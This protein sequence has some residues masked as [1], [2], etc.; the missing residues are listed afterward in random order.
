[1]TAAAVET[2]GLSKR[3]PKVE[4]LKE[5]SLRI[6][7]GEIVALLGPNGAGKTTW[8]SIVCGLSRPTA[9][10]AMVLGYDVRREPL[11]ARRRLGLVP[12][13]LS[14]DPFFSPRE[15]LRFQMGYYGQRADDT[16]ILEVLTALG[17]R[18][19][20]DS[21]ARELSGGMKR[22]LLI[23]KALVPRPKVLFL[24]EPT[25]G[26]DVAL[27]RELWAY[28]RRLRTAGTTIVLT[29]HYLEEAQSL[30]DRVAVIDRGELITVDSPR[31]LMQRYG[32]KRVQL[33]LAQPL[34]SL[35]GAL[36]AL[37]ATLE[38]GG[39]T[40]SCAPPDGAMG[41]LLAA[42]AALPIVDLRTDEPSL[43]QVFLQLTQEGARP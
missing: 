25:A 5:V 27:R 10:R 41:Q 33:T 35:P 39:R 29:T 36:T 21:N 8:I 1:V 20:A 3:Y 11:E 38:A 24:D 4:A 42:A 2:L 43:E 9:G 31:G 34:E 32:R 22:R 40:V 12:Q 18:D 30:A 23:A 17:L 13:E 19:R 16:H 7:P 14:F 6:E 26:V 28:V 37:G 15:A